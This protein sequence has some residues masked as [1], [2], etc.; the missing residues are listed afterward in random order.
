M[1]VVPTPWDSADAERL[2]EPKEHAGNR[3]DEDWR[4]GLIPVRETLLQDVRS[5]A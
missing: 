1:T 5:A 2:S 4:H 3:A